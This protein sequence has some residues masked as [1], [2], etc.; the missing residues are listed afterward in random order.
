[1]AA[2]KLTKFQGSL[3]GAVLG[4]CIGALFEGEW[5]NKIEMN[6]ILK[7]VA[8]I[9]HAKSSQTGQENSPKK[10]HDDSLP[11]K[12]K[13]KGEYSF[14]DDTAMARS[15]AKSLIQH[16]QLNAKHLAQRFTEEYMREPFRGYGGSV[17]TVFHGLQEQEYS[18]VYQPASQQFEGKGSYGNGGAM[19]IVPAALFACRKGYTFEQLADLTEKITR[20]THSHP[21]AIQGA[22]LQSYAVYL[23]LV[24]DKLDVD[25]F[26]DSLISKMKPLE[27]RM[28]GTLGDGSDT[29]AERVDGKADSNVNADNKSGETSAVSGETNMDSSSTSIDTGQ[30]SGEATVGV[31]EVTSLPYCQKLE[32]VREFVKRQEQPPVEEI[33]QELGVYIAALDSVPA[34]IY[35]FLR[36]MNPIDELQDRNG[37]ERT[38]LY[39]ISHGGDTDTVATMAGAIAGAYYGLEALPWAWQNC[40]EGA[41]DA[42][43]DAELLWKL[44]NNP[45]AGKSTKKGK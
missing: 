6:K 31:G 16:N 40:S 17:A 12:K 4:D 3:V 36:A 7:E 20:L 25:T 19:R 29:G 34:A 1:M 26:I 39:S 8:K 42:L 21:Q 43:Q 33:T 15:V 22:V 30:Q 24:S 35:C 41:S 44:P 9:E 2:S 37:F 5:F 45:G 27:E 18:D 28:R 13:R 38:L 32:K 23:A 11:A 14:T 10:G